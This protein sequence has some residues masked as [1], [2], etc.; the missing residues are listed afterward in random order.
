MVAEPCDYIAITVISSKAAN[1]ILRTKVPQAA[2]INDRI[3]AFKICSIWHQQSNVSSLFHDEV[4][5][6]Q[7]VFYRCPSMKGGDTIVELQ[8]ET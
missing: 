8:L 5:S 6:M 1:S 7:P 3:V 4:S 2:D